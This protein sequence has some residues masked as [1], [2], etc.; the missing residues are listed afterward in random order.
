MSSYILCKHNHALRM[1][2]DASTLQFYIFDLKDKIIQN[3]KFLSVNQNSDLSS[4]LNYT[5]QHES[6]GIKIL[7][8]SKQTNGYQDIEN[9]LKSRQ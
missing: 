7:K 6:G 8:F 3:I 9:L 4:K 2:T 1:L 5:H